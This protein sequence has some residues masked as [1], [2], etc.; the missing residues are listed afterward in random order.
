MKRLERMTV[1]FEVAA[2]VVFSRHHRRQHHAG[3]DVRSRLSVRV[4][5]SSSSRFTSTLLCFRCDM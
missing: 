4:L 3:Q 1:R 5:R 2:E